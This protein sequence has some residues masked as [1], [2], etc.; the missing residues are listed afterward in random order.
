MS[1]I[2]QIIN[3]E[4]MA[5]SNCVSVFSFSNQSSTTAVKYQKIIELKKNK[6]APVIR[7][8]R[9]KPI[10]IKDINE[11]NKIKLDKIIK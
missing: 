3:K 2:I 5:K 11:K 4:N 1:K 9:F 7:L 8:L 6:T 10:F